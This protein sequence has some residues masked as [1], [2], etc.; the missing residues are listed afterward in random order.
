MEIIK[1]GLAE[2]VK[3]AAARQARKAARLAAKG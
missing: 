1:D 2:E 3:K